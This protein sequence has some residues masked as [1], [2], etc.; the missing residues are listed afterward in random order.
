MRIVAVKT[1]ETSA[2]VEDR[3]QVRVAGVPFARHGGGGHDQPPSATR[4]PGRIGRSPV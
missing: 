3:G 4:R 1:Y 2:T